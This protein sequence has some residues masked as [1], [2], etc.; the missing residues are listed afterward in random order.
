MALSFSP[1]KIVTSGLIFYLDVANSKSYISGS[2]TTTDLISNI[3]GILVNGVGY[4]SANL[5]SFVFDGIDDAI[6]Y[7]FNEKIR[8]QVGET[9]SWEFWVN[10][11]SNQGGVSGPLVSNLKTQ[12]LRGFSFKIMND[13]KID[14]DV[15]NGSYFNKRSVPSVN[16][17]LWHQCLV[18]YNGSTNNSGVK[19]Y[20][21]GFEVSTTTNVNS[22]LSPYVST[23]EINIGTNPGFPQF[24]EGNISLVKLY[25]RVLTS[26]EVL[27][28][29]NALKYRFI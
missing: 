29:Y 14:F 6:T 27:Q 4:D 3:Y 5:G 10:T 19:L 23:D 20:I 9:T 25:D 11:T 15:R 1:S 28:N 26:T 18:T 12:A 8:S 21:D 13:G 17:G 2:T 24:Y 22:T 16:D 7:S